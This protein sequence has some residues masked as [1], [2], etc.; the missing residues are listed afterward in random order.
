MKDGR[1]MH[2][3]LDA[4]VEDAADAGIHASNW[5]AKLLGDLLSPYGYGAKAVGDIWPLPLDADAYTPRGE[6]G[7]LWM[8]L[9]WSDHPDPFQDRDQLYSPGRWH[10][11]LNYLQEGTFDHSACYFA[12]L[13]DEGALM[14]DRAAI[15]EVKRVRDDGRWLRFQVSIPWHITEIPEF[16]NVFV[17]FLKRWTESTEASFGI[18]GDQPNADTTA[19]EYALDL[20]Y[21]WPDKNIPNSRDL[22]RGYSWLTLL[23]QE[24]AVRLGGAAQL[25]ETG[26]FSDVHEIGTGSLLLQATRNLEEFQP[27]VVGKVFSALAPVL[28]PGVPCEPQVGR[29][30]PIVYGIDPATVRTG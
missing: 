7:S 18:A 26:A 3:E 9:S 19:L 30:Y 29:S 14:E 16:S 22:L 21:S 11:F 10:K 13:D 20:P 2:C 8:T 15:V 6:P 12:P 23:P 1:S 25:R 28:L 4:M 17:H 5:Y 24:L 27:P